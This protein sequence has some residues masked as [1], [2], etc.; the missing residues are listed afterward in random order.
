MSTEITTTEEE[1]ARYTACV[2]AMAASAFGS[3]FSK[4]ELKGLK[5]NAL[6]DIQSGSYRKTEQ[7]YKELK[8]LNL[9]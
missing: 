2:T 9:K 4:K 7:L 5:T 1:L 6:K 3:F 8:Q